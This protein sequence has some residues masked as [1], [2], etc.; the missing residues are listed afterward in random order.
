M[1]IWGSEARHKP[2]I[3]H[4][5]GLVAKESVYR[6]MAD[7]K[8]LPGY[9]SA[10]YVENAIERYTGIENAFGKYSVTAIVDNFHA[11]TSSGPIE[12]PKFEQIVS[13]IET[14]AYATADTAIEWLG[15]PVIP[16]VSRG[17]VAL[18]GVSLTQKA[19]IARQ[20]RVRGRCTSKNIR[21]K[22]CS[23]YRGHE[24]VPIQRFQGRHDYS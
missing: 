1:S 15:E 19:W 22:R 10:Y 5:Y 12:Y 23:L 24:L 13:G 11:G 3:G 14:G 9:G 16:G 20:L 21:G 6:A 7:R 17:D 18:T 4:L 8:T 2:T